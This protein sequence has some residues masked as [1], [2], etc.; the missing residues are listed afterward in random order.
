M[1]KANLFHHFYN[2][3]SKD[4]Y[5]IILFHKLEINLNIYSNSNNIENE[6]KRDAVVETIEEDI[7]LKHIDPNMISIIRSEIMEKN[8]T[9]GMYSIYRRV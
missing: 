7:R 5:D 2:R 6:K 8:F 1:F 4:I 9:V 3:Q